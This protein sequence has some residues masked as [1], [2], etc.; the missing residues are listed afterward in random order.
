V[1]LLLDQG[2]PRTA[3]VLLREQGFDAT[4]TAEVGLSS[5]DDKD[6]I[7]WC[8]ANGAL[9]A[10]VDADFHTLIALSGESA[11]SAIR[12]RIEGLKGPQVAEILREILRDHADDLAAGALVTIQAQRVRLRRL[13]IGRAPK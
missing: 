4:H 12:I 13:P 10:T 7:E 8:R 2:V 1:K 9:V 11:P 3:A 5:A 6:I